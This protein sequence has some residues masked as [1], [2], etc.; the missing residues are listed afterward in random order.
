MNAFRILLIASAVAIAG[1]APAQDQSHGLKIGVLSDISGPASA[2]SGPGSMVAAKL[3]L[4]DFGGEVLGK[5]VEI[6]AGDFL[7]K[8]DVG[9][10]IARRWFD[11]ENVDAITDV[12]SSPLA[13]A[14]QDVIRE[15]KRIFLMSGPT[16]SD[17]TGRSCSPNSVRLGR[18]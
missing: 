5:P 13:L 12:P 7:L 6:V 15:K 8:V 3:A 2:N 11:Q 9:A 17:L 16:S 4:E 1:A 14:I 10:L 18:P